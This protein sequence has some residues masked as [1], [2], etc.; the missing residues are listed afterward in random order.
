MLIDNPLDSKIAPRQADVIP[1][2]REDTTPPVMN[3]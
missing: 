2:P 1:L 3:T